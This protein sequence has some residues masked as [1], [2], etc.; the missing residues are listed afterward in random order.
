MPPLW[1]PSEERIK[2]ANITR[3]MQYLG[4]KFGKKLQDFNSLYQWSIENREDFWAS[5][6]DFGGVISSKS[7]NKVLKDSP[8]MIGAKWFLD[9]RLNF[10]ENLLRF[11]D[12]KTAIIFKGEGRPVKKMTYAELYDEV[13]RLAKALRD[14]GVKAGDRVGAYVPNMIEPV[15]AMLAAA[16]IGAGRLV[17]RISVSRVFSTASVKSSQRCCSPLT[18]TS[19]MVS[20]SVR[21]RR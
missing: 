4:E 5:M 1:V 19:T 16:S 21:W 8:S 15:V 7:Y 13:A 10:A 12:D 20:R 2:N 11:K 17:P 18:A 14:M 3:Y 6:W 9:S